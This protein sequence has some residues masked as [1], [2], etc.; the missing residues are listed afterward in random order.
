MIVSP[1]IDTGEFEVLGGS[2]DKVF[3]KET[4]VVRKFSKSVVEAEKEYDEGVLSLKEFKRR[5]GELER[6]CGEDLKSEE[7][8]VL[9]LFGQ[10]FSLVD[11]KNQI[12]DLEDADAEDRV[13]FME[14]SVLLQ[15][16]VVRIVAGNVDLEKNEFSMPLAR[17]F[18]FLTDT[19]G[20]L[21]VSDCVDMKEN[22][23]LVEGIRGMVT[24]ALLFKKE[25]W[26]VSLPPVELDVYCGIDLVVRNPETGKYYAVD[27]T[28]SLHNRVRGE[29]VFDLT[30]MEPHFSLKGVGS[31]K[32]VG[33][34]R[35]NVPP[36]KDSRGGLLDE[37]KKLYSSK[38][39]LAVR[40]LGI[41]NNK[42]QED[43]V[44]KL[45]GLQ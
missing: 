32:D 4:G 44:Y 5:I 17:Y 21:M 31:W 10:L 15:Q 42:M 12:G 9:S 41:P 13:G 40:S 11:W 6:D 29:D 33:F 38:G 16:E 25:G 8:A 3:P 2:S 34:L 35:L 14:E 27:V 37:A 22:A 43:F 39:G 23:R 20:D 45:D 24:S 36:L 19:F 26:E 30:A 28:A 18:L 1:D 7:K